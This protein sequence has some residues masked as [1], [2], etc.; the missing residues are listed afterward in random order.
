M[1]KESYI[2]LL[3]LVLFASCSTQKNTWL[4][5]SYHQT[6]TR[7]NI[8]YNGQIA[9]DEGLDAIDKAHKDDFT[10]LISLYTIS[11]HEAASAAASQMDRTIEKCRKCIKLHS[12]KKK[13]KRDPK[14]A[15]DPEYKAWYNQE[16]F[17][18][19]MDDAWILLAKAEFHKGDFLGSIGTFNYIIRHYHYD[20]D[21]VAQCQLW[22]VRA[23]A[24]M[25]WLYEAED[26]FQKVQ[27]DDLSR[28]NA[29]LYAATAADL[30]L[31]TEQYKDAIPFLKIA[32]KDEK[33]SERA[34][35]YFLLGQLYE[36]NNEREAALLA[37]KR[38]L[39]LSPSAEMDFAARMKAMQLGGNVKGLKRMAKQYKN[40]DKL[41]QIYG[42]VGNIYLSKKDTAKALENYVLAIENSTQG[43]LEKAAVLIQAGDIYYVQRDYNRAQPCYTEAVSIITT[44][45]K[46]Y[47]RISKRAET[48]DELIVEYNTVQLQD[49]LQRLSKMTEEE[50]LKIVEKIIADLI[51]AEK[52]AAEKAA[53][54]ARDAKNNTGLQSVNT[55]NMIG[56]GGDQGDWYFYNAQLI[57]SGKQT[58]M[59]QWSNRPLEDN[60]RRLTKTMVASMDSFFD[61]DADDDE[62]NSDE[63]AE[64]STSSD[65]TSTSGSASTDTKDPQFY[66]Q[67]IP[68]TAA[69]LAASDS[70]IATAL[71]NM[72]YIYQDKVGDQALSDETFAEFARRFPYESRLVELYYMKYLTAYKLGNQANVLH[73]RAEILRLFPGTKQAEIAA[74][75]DYFERLKQMA[76]A[77]DSLYLNTY[78]QFKQA[79]YKA[80]KEN[81]AYVETAYPL[82]PLMPRFLFLNAVAVAKTEG[83]DAFVESLRDMVK[84][85]PESE[86]GAMAKD[87]LAMMN[88]G[89]E[90]QTGGSAVG[91]IDRTGVTEETLDTALLDKQFSTERKES[92]LVYIVISLDENE[93]NNLLYQV[94]LFNFSQFLIKDFDLKQIPMFALRKSA[95][96]ISGFDTY[97]E[98]LWYTSLILENADLH[99]LFER[100]Q[101]DILP[102]TESNSKLLNTR[103]TIDEYKTFQLEKLLI[104]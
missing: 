19:N 48:L 3:S 63:N 30:R 93:L 21:V 57:R 96:M 5:R 75:P 23:Y 28:K 88:M 31:K 74:Q 9:F 2:L 16:E 43:G 20:K 89:M 42:A 102:I 35:Y 100:L 13:P 95:L 72:V 8:Q 64:N 65:S 53:Q 92:A 1:R 46:D 56:G 45:S 77:P 22:T 41:D 83:Q 4:T 54:A 66:L 49:S 58:F 60:W 70:L 32:V 79:D 59:Q 24:E 6:T 38:V 33:R 98:A 12:I 37:Y 101:A 47:K 62:E 78:N 55:Q 44:S 73:Y 84:R 61:D 90:S 68:T 10:G 82:S 69:E 97:D 76:G 71:Y 17:N 99:D 80:V 39:K 104:Q 26:V 67:Q 7:F 86:P 87:M 85:Y 11:N 27:Q 14:R 25:G 52:E 18:R 51:Q 15:N 81:T 36:R 40:R 103:F 91:T 29:W 50:Q 94:A 34:R